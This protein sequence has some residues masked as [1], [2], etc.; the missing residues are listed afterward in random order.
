A[1][2][3]DVSILSNKARVHWISLLLGGEISWC[4]IAGDHKSECVATAFAGQ[5]RRRV[6]IDNRSRVHRLQRCLENVDAFKKEWALFFK[7]NRKALIGGNNGLVRFH[8]SEVR[9]QGEVECNRGSQPELHRD[10][11]IEFQVFVDEATRIQSG[12]AGR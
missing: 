6:W 8:L 2:H 9:V 1:Q 3:R 11:G 4:V 10:A 7:E 12:R 5:L